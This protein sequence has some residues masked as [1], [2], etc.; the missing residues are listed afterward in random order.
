MIEKKQKH[1]RSLIN[2]LIG[3]SAIVIGF[4]I[5]SLPA[6]WSVSQW[7]PLAIKIGL[8]M[9]LFVYMAFL[10]LILRY[11]LS[12][13]ALEK[14]IEKNVSKGEAGDYFLVGIPVL[15]CYAFAVSALFMS[16]I[17]GEMLFTG[18]RESALNWILYLI[19]NLIRA[20]L[21]DFAETYRL[22]VSPIDHTRNFFV[23]SF[24]FSFRTTISIG[25]FSIVV[26]S[27]RKLRN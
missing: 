2:S 4:V 9:G 24:V 8:G 27:W 12:P 1:T 16:R 18:S 21:M 3:G 15:F 25:L 22:Q 20:G 19:D 13:T 11:S 17:W 6:I 7:S 10:V 26:R 23:C 14:D 5:A